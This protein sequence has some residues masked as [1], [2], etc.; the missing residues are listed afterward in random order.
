LPALQSDIDIH[1]LEGRELVEEMK[2]IAEMQGIDL[3]LA[4]LNKTKQ[5]L[6]S[7]ETSFSDE[8]IKTRENV[9]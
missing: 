4:D 3:T 2:R 1:I 7:L 8:I 5:I 6:D 9:D